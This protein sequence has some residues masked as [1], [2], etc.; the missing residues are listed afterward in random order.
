MDRDHG[1]SL[2]GEE[3]SR[4]QNRCYHGADGVLQKVPVS[5]SAPQK[6]KRGLRGKIVEN[7]KEELAES[8]QQ[9][10][11]LVKSYV[12]P[13][14]AR[15]QAVKDAGNVS[16]DVLDP[17]KRARLNFHD[18]FRP[19]DTL[20]AELDIVNNRLLGVIVATYLESPQDQVG[21]DVRFGALADGTT[22]PDQIVLD[23]KAKK[24]RV[25][26]DNSGYRKLGH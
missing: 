24:L 13:D 11:D 21:L 4:K 5:A 6:K 18:Y 22:Y 3:K 12:P 23:G 9:A 15:L 19:G 17:G 1:V 7:K 20:S 26:V 8:M 14:P 2:K 25:A 10:V 16:I